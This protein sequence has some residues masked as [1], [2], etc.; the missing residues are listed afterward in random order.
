[1][2]SQI[3]NNRALYRLR[4]HFPQVNKIKEATR[5]LLISVT[6]EDSQSATKKDPSGCAL[7]RACVRQQVADS[8]IIGIAY[9]WLIKGKTATRYR[10][11]ATVAREITSFD[12]HQD[13]AAGKSYRLCAIQPSARMGNKK[14]LKKGATNGRRPEPLAVHKTA[15]IRRSPL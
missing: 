10:T 6:T 8:A 9:S 4:R 7:A 1:M 15:N 13:F 2:K 5:P 3:Q 14:C 11:S 12:R